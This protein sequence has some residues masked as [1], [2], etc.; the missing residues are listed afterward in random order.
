[1][2]P[3]LVKLLCQGEIMTTMEKLRYMIK[4]GETVLRTE[5]RSVGAL[6]IHKVACVE[7]QPLGVIG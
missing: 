7:W 4:E 6:S 2:F 3:T 5:R 1:M